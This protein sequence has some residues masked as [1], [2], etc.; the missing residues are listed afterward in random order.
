[1]NVAF[2]A[3][4][5]APSHPVPS[6]DR[7]VARLL[8]AALSA[9][10]HRVETA[11]TFRS[12]D[13]VGDRLRQARLG[14][15]G[16][17]I[18]H[19]MVRRYRTGPPTGR[20]DVWF[21]Y[22]LYYKAPDWLGPTVSAALGI[23]YVVAEASDAP[24]R[25]AGA[26][27]IGHR[28]ARAAIGHADAL[29]CLNPNDIP[30]LEP[31]T[32]GPGRIH[33]LK[34]FLDPAPFRAAA[35]S[36]DRH[37]R[38]IAAA[39]GLDPAAPWLLAVGMMREGHKLASYR[40]L[41]DALTRLGARRWQLIVVGDGPARAVVTSAL[42]S[43]GT[44]VRFTGELDGARLPP[45][46]AASD[47]LVWP[48]VREA[49]GMSLLEAQAAGLPVVAGRTDGVPAVVAD[50]RTGLLPSPEDAAAF[51]TAVAMLLDHPE[52]RHAMGAA[53]AARVMADHDLRGAATMLDRVLR[54]V[55]ERRA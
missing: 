24:K 33:V 12:R 35:A 38:T 28:A 4:L 15:L 46:Y 31:Q 29:I 23:P 40:I 34:P 26:W 49:F 45:F 17:R 39:L 50:G 30:C 19:R 47:L 1:M 42:T 18:A 8:I 54:H 21:T 36:R 27:E 22:H 16:W 52:R 7:R 55:Q 14:E 10:G 48:A 9:A 6:G 3:P 20:P 53:A 37:R 5:K 44:R 13:G 41:A 51:G 32:G 2:Y 43:L 11:S 25:A